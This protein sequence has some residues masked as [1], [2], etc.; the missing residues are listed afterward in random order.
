MN[1]TFSTGDYYGVY[2]NRVDFFVNP[3]DTT[4]GSSGIYDDP[5]WGQYGTV[6]YGANYLSLGWVR[7]NNNINIATMGSLVDGTSSTIFFAERYMGMKNADASNP[8]NLYYN[9]WAYGEEFW[10][11][12]NPIF[13]A[14]P[15]VTA[16]PVIA[17]RF[18]VLPTEGNS[19]ATVNPLKAHCPRSYGILV[20]FGDG[21]TSMVSAAINDNVWWA[22]MTPDR[23]EIVDPRN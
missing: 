2:R 7:S 1:L 23:G 8:N 14:Y 12:W 9:I 20:G 4:G 16:N 11:Q 15:E 17:H 3:C 5:A 18:Q 13:G 19:L 10:Y 22:A 21:S 6:G